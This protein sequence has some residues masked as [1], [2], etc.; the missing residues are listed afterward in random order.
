MK[1]SHA[2]SRV[3]NNIINMLEQEFGK[4]A[5]LTICCGK[6]HD[7]LGMTL[8]FSIGGKVQICMEEYIKNMLTELLADMD[9]TAT[10]PAA[11][12]LFKVNETPTYLDEKEAMFFH[13]NMVKL[14]FLYK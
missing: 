9:G 2:D 10:T 4:E 12:H 6:I 1:I 5:P 8:D 14:L 3:V 7:C 13:H 11:E